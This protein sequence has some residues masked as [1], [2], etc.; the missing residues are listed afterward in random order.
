MLEE[1]LHH[2]DKLKT[3]ESLSSGYVY[4]LL[5]YVDMCAKEKDGSSE[6]AIWRAQ[7][8]YAT[9]RYIVDKAWRLGREPGASNNCL[10]AS[11]KILAGL[12]SNFSLDTGS[13]C[14]ITCIECEPDR[15]FPCRTDIGGTGHVH[16]IAHHGKTAVK[17][18]RSTP[19]RSFSAIST[20]SCIRTLPRRRQS[21]VAVDRGRDQEQA[22]S[23]QAP[24][25]ET[26]TSFRLRSAPAANAQHSTSLSSRC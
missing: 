19:P 23:T 7:F 11:R 8:K 20:L 21:D 13:F 18:R 12:L 17:H 3:E 25:D 5:R 24:H 10:R 15:R 26:V 9:R 16:R 6:A 14:S 1:A 4:R 22:C 2:L